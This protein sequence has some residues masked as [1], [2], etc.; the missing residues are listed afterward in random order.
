M[1]LVLVL[2]VQLSLQQSNQIR[3]PG[4]HL[5]HFVREVLHPLDLPCQVP[6]RTSCIRAELHCTTHP[7]DLLLQFYHLLLILILT[8]MHSILALALALL[9]LVQQVL[10]CGGALALALAL[11]PLISRRQLPTDASSSI[12]SNVDWRRLQLRCWRRDLPQR[13]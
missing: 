9:M 3:L 5:R 11:L 13:W 4:V 8:P 10:M 7:L 2:L 6:L 1:L 12:I